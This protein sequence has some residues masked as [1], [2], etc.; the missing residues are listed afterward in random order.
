MPR[1]GRPDTITAEHLRSCLDGFIP[2]A[3]SAEKRMQELAAI[4]ECTEAEMLPEPM[5]DQIR[6]PAAKIELV[7]RFEALKGEIG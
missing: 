7:R 6:N 5:R 2:S 1:S 3:D 4:L